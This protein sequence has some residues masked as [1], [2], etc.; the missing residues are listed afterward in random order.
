LKK[1]LLIIGLV[2]LSIF[3]FA[4]PNVDI[5]ENSTS[6]N[7]Q[8]RIFDLTMDKEGHILDYSI[9]DFR[10]KEYKLIYSYAKDSFNLLDP[11]TEEEIVPIDYKIAVSDNQEYIDMFFFFEGNGFKKY[12]FYND[13]NFH[14]EVEFVDV[15]GLV[16]LPTISYRPGIR[17]MQSTMVSFIKEIPNTGEN[18]EA[19]VAVEAASQIDNQLRYTTEGRTLSQVYMGPLKRTFMSEVFQNEAYDRISALLDELGAFGFFSKIFYW[20]VY[21]LYWLN[22]ITGN[23]GWAIIIFTVIIRLGLY[24]L[25]HKQQQSMIKMREIQP[26]VDKLKK[27]YKNAQKLQEETMKLYKEKNVNPMGGCLPTLIQLPVFIVLWQTIQYFGEAFAYNP[28]FLFWSDLSQG[29]FGTNFIFILISLGAYMAIALLSAQNS[30][31]AWQQIAMSTIFPLL[32]SSLP[33]GVFLYY[34]SNALI[35]LLITL[36]NNKRHGIKGIGIRELFGLGPKPVRR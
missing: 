5:S 10:T 17:Q 33:A 12:R 27:K 30:K 11:E 36:Y 4:I 1:Q 31:M 9:V 8:T 6:I 18:L 28:R 23:F 25:Y 26:E 3:V 20:F 13:P 35:Q 7:L 34:T 24:P 16:T 14:Y 19:L 22:E 2:V 29:G 32:L 21:F 15:K